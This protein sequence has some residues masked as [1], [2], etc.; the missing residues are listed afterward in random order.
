M[1]SKASA[2]KYEAL[3]PASQA[4]GE[5]RLLTLLP[6][7]R[8]S[9][10]C[11][12]LQH[13]SFQHNAKYE[14]LSY[15][16]GNL[17]LANDLKGCLSPLK[18]DPASTHSIHLNGCAATITYNL[19]GA[20]QQLRSDS[21]KRVLWVD[22]LCIN[23]AD[24]LEK[25]EQVKAM[26]KIYHGASRVVTWL[27]E[28][29]EFVDLAF[30]TLEQFCWA[31]KV[32]V[33][34]YCAQVRGLPASEISDDIMT[35]VI[36]SEVLSGNE[37]SPFH[38]TR[39]IHDKVIREMSMISDVSAEVGYVRETAATRWSTDGS[40]ATAIITNNSSV[41]N[42]PDIKKR[43]D[44]VREVFRQR[45][46]WY[47]LWIV[48]ELLW[49][50]EVIVLCGQRQ[51]N[52]VMMSLPIFLMSV[53]INKS[54]PLNAFFRSV[55]REFLVEFDT[56][57]S[58]PIGFCLSAG[59]GSLSSLIQEYAE[60]LCSEPRDRIYALLTLS[61]PSI[62][63][64]PDYLKSVAEVYVE[65]THA[66]INRDQNL[67]ILCAAVIMS[68]SRVNN[69]LPYIDLPSWVP[70]FE[71]VLDSCNLN[72]YGGP[73][74]QYHCSGGPLPASW[75]KQQPFDTNRVLKLNGYFY[76][77]IRSAS[78]RVQIVEA[79][80]SRI[81]DV[82]LFN[83]CVDLAEQVSEQS[84]PK[85]ETWQALFMDLYQS[86]NHSRKTR[87]ST[88]E[89]TRQ[90]FEA[91][92][93]LAQSPSTPSPAKF[94]RILCAC[95]DAKAIC[96]TT[97]GNIALVLGDVNPGDLV[98]V[99]KGATNPFILRPAKGGEALERQK[100]THSVSTFYQFVGGAYVHGIMDGEVLAMGEEARVVRKSLFQKALAMVDG[101]VVRESS[102]FLI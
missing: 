58:K 42:L 84:P 36:E 74:N 13:A 75:N 91:D 3:R 1:S 6:G 30:D 72:Q 85:I 73:L 15:T 27:G 57:L 33:L 101:S 92:L 22:A 12:T 97:N 61:I 81:Q 48:Q 89:E 55:D 98:F 100:K 26:A 2:Y 53:V 95:L 43:L 45:T 50:P 16:W 59:S 88:S 31:T 11:C 82:D 67:N 38:E 46:Y 51:V 68:I 34:E 62:E 65:T 77:R 66:I 71:S 80:A 41:G 40:L 90:A 35:S 39:N 87:I 19:E 99:A 54:H 23:Q 5:F 32:V 14:A 21:A 70:Y 69:C 17:K 86:P 28:Q 78:S 63:I 93:H 7:P 37:H 76:G 29:D 8:G 20:L 10:I 52:M 18:G 96:T 4:D 94:M 47:R 44:S 25:S 79:V 83:E 24:L 60:N 102:V 64:D 56:V 9:Q 49:A